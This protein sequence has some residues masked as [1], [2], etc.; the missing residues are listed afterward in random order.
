[1]EF[2]IENEVHIKRHCK[3][4]DISKFSIDKTSWRITQKGWQKLR[5][6]HFWWTLPLKSKS[7]GKRQVGIIFF[8]SKVDKICCL[9]RAA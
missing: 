2:D 9:F 3:G 1:V 5:Y 8:V 7:D 4:A 6:V